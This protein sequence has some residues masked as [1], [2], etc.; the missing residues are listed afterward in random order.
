ME[1]LQAGADG[2]ELSALIGA[3]SERGIR[4]G[5]RDDGL[6]IAAPKGTLTSEL[7]ERLVRHKAELVRWLRARSGA[8]LPRR[9]DMRVRLQTRDLRALPDRE[10]E[11]QRLVDADSVQPFDL[12]RGPPLRVGALQLEDEHFVLLINLHHI[13]GDGQ[14]MEILAREISALYGA[15]RDG[16]PADLPA[17]PLQYGDY[18]A[19][20]RKRLDSASLARLQN[21]WQERLR[22]SPPCHS[23]PTDHPRPLHA[24]HRGGGATLQVSDA[25]AHALRALSRRSDATL[26]STLFA[27]FAVAQHRFGG[28]ADLVVGTVA[29]NRERAELDSLIGFFVNTVVLRAVVDPQASFR[30]LLAAVAADVRAAFGHQDLPFEQLVELLKPARTAAVHPLF[31]LMFTVVHATAEAEAPDDEAQALRLEPI[32]TAPF[33]KFD[34]SLAVHDRRDGLFCSLNY[35]TDLFTADSAARLLETYR[36]VVEAVAARPDVALDRLFAPTPAAVP[37]AASVSAQAWFEQHGIGAELPVPACGVHALFEAQAVQAGECVAVVFGEAS[38]T[39]AELNARAN[40]LA[41]ELRGL[42]VGPE[43]LV[44]LYLPRSIDQIVGVLAIWKAGGAYVPLDPAHPPGRLVAMLSDAGPVAILTHT[45]LS[46]RVPETSAVVLALDAPGAWDAQPTDNLDDAGDPQRLAYVLYTSGSTGTPKGVEIVHGALT[47]LSAAWRH[48]RGG[49]FVPGRRVAINAPLVFDVSV[50]QL[51]QLLDGATLYPVPEQTRLDID[52]LWRFI[53]VSQLDEFDCTPSLLQ[54]L[55]DTMTPER[56]AQLP[57]LLLVG[58]EAIGERQWR[59]LLDLR[60]HGIEACNG[61]GPTECTVYTTY[62]PVVPASPLPVIG[63]PVPNLRLYVLDEH[64]APCGVGAAGELCVAGWGVARGYRARPELTAERFVQRTV[65]GREERLYRTGDWVRW[66][67]DGTLEYCGRRDGQIKLRGFRIEL[68]EITTALEAQPG[69]RQAVVIVAGEGAAAQLVAYVVGEVDGDTLAQALAQRLPAYMVPGVWM[70]LEAMPLNTNG[71]VDVRALPAPTLA[72]REFVAPR[73][74]VEQTLQDIWQ[75]VLDHSPIGVHDSF[76]ALGG[77]SL[78]AVR[79]LAEVRRAYGRTVTVGRL[80]GNDDIAGLADLLGAAEPEK[81]ASLVIL[82]AGLA[83]ATPAL[84]TPPVGGG[85]ACYHWL[86]RAFPPQQT[87]FAGHIDVQ[88]GMPALDASI[89][90]AARRYL[91]ALFAQS[92]DPPGCLLGWSMGGVIAHE[93]AAQMIDRGMPAPLLVMIDSNAP[94]VLVA[95]APSERSVAATLAA[96]LGLPDAAFAWSDEHGVAGLHWLLVDAGLLPDE[97]DVDQLRRRL[98]VIRHHLA[99][100]RRHQPR[101]IAVPVVL[102][103][104]MQHGSAPHDNGWT[105]FVGEL[106]V[107]PVDADH[108][109]I[110]RAPHAERIARELTTLLDGAGQVAARPEATV[111]VD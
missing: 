36:E 73:N 43:R 41:R 30:Q 70:V 55:L 3:L 59:Q 40:A 109:A 33:A 75:R 93:I 105:P 85:A 74:E 51:L 34:L 31:Q 17:L 6:D 83:G 82:R 10:A 89:A 107:H 14:S 86:A 102:Y 48:Q 68:G 63:R 44:G 88:D 22:D 110:M 13:V 42:G 50:Q 21:F 61:Y 57:K 64:G 90:D 8:S 53:E 15:E 54:V 92:S 95:D 76:F 39:Y 45:A 111:D 81:P 72:A 98:D 16:L 12:E 47:S 78:L 97:V 96:E 37:P 5:L 11:M 24:S 77:H 19:W 79:M 106:R 62:G 87:V 28:A 20:Q 99:I 94:R 32:E 27:A 29:A 23:I 49:E 66:K 84:L 71:K 18:A 69:V 65:F 25:A 100:S 56:T 108:F 58:G 91:D 35:A 52:A 7:K 9:P 103:K 80:L 104:A 2:A 101:P 26:F 46:S 60:E 1:H 67:D 4:I 38:I